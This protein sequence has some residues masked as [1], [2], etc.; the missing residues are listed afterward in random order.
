MPYDLSEEKLPFSLDAE[1]SILGAIILDGERITDVIGSL[2]PEHFYV[3]LNR[4]IYSVLVQMS[5]SSQAIDIVTVLD[6]V[7]RQGLFE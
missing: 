1:Q 5:M 6:N 4:D 7:M 3:G 2:H